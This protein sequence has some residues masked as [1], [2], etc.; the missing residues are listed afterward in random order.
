[1]IAN[2]T[3]RAE[4]ELSWIALRLVLARVAGDGRHDGVPFQRTSNG[5]PFIA[6]APISFSLSHSHGFALI[7]AAATPSLALGVDIQA[8][9]PLRM[10]E[11]RLARMVAA[12]DRLAGAAAWPA[13]TDA[14]LRYDAALQA[15]VRIEAVAKATGLGLAHVLARVGVL[16]A[17]KPRDGDAEVAD[18]RFA[19]ALAELDVRDVEIP[20]AP[21]QRLHA[22]IAA[23]RGALASV[24]HL[25]VMPDDM[26]LLPT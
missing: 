13:Q 20:A 3:V 14:I 19:N 5:K 25:N 22:A 24:P 26:A 7:A 8:S 18:H 17:S 6:N 16:A 10:S 21:S 11:D 4:R 15:F 2:P 23:T 9:V 1:M 12:G